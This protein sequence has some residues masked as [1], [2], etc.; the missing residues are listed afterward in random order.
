M[1]RERI[2][3]GHCVNAGQWNEIQHYQDFV[4]FR[5]FAAALTNLP[6]FLTEP[7]CFIIEFNLNNPYL[8]IVPENKDIFQ[9]NQPE[10]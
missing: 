3:G 4:G 7:Y 9:E 10:I 5:C 2:P 1:E 6:F 8:T